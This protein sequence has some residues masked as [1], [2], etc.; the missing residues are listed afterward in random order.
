VPWEAKAHGFL[1]EE[2]RDL[3]ALRRC[4]ATDE[5]RDGHAFGVFEPRGEVD[6]DLVIMRCP[7]DLGDRS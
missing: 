4:G 3:L 1:G 6:D 7:V 5:E 2:H